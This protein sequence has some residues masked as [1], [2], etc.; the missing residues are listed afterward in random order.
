MAEADLAVRELSRSVNRSSGN[1]ERLFRQ[2]ASE[3]NRNISKITKD[4]ATA[5]ASQ[6]RDLNKL[7]SQISESGDNS[8]GIGA[9]IDQQKEQIKNY[10]L[11]YILDYHTENK[12][13]YIYKGNCL[14]KIC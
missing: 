5:I 10:T 13:K 3:N 4:L 1:T 9:K 12:K 6:R 2:A 11:E 14:L 8:A 7:A